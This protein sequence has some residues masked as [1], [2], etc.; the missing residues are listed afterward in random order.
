MNHK[1]TIHTE[2]L[3]G[4]LKGIRN[5]YMG[6]NST[7]HLYVI[8][9]N[10]CKHIKSLQEVAGQPAFYILVGKK[11]NTPTGYIGQTTD[12]ANRKNDHLQKKEWWDT[13]L[14]FIADNQKIYGD[15]VKFLEYLGIS[16]AQEIGCFE[17]YNEANPKRP[18]IATYRINDMEVFF[19]DIVFLTEF[20]G[21]NIFSQ[22]TPV[23][24]STENQ[25]LPIFSI[26]IPDRVK[27]KGFYLGEAKGVYDASIK[28]M[29]ILKDSIVAESPTPSYKKSKDFNNWKK[30]VKENC[31]NVENLLVVKHDV[32][33]DSP[34]TAAQMVRAASSNGWKEWTNEEGRTLD[35]CFRK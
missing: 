14:V 3:D 29:I 28:S 32:V 6:V 15:D 9:R 12:F 31:K 35:A 21:C 2:L 19:R 4:S 17:L 11:D 34:S 20:Y 26:Q 1:R 27:G 13:A 7:C 16:K 5:I 23:S 24:S 22:I 30:W 8:P 10:L 33:V 18:P 25:P